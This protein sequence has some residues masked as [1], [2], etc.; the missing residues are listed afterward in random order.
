MRLHSKEQKLVDDV[1]ENFNF[2]RCHR[3]MKHLNWGWGFPNTEVPSIEK[4]KKSALNRIESAIEDLKT[5]VK[6]NPSPLYSSSSGGLCATVYRD[7]YKNVVSIKLEF[8][9]TEWHEEN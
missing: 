5:D 3:V 4:L 7:R 1:I 9:L 8:I 6:R 2:N